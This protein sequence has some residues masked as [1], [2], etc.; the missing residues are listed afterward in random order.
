MSFL[1]EYIR[2]T[3][4][5]GPVRMKL[6]I[7]IPPDLRAISRMFRSAGEE[8]YIVGG[9]VRDTLLNKTPKDYD[10][11][12]GAAP[13]VVIDIISQDPGNKVDLTG[14]SFGVVRVWTPDGSEYEIAT[15]RKDI[16]SGRRPDR[17]EFTSIE[18][19]VKRRDLTINALFYDMGSEEVVDYVGG[20]RDIKAG[21]VK[22]VGDPMQR[23]QEDKLRILRA[24]RFAARLGSDLD[25][26]TE[27]AI[28]AG[29]NLAD[30][31]PDRIRDEVVKG[32][33][34]AQNAT[35]FLELLRN[36]DLYSQIFPGL[37][38]DPSAG[39][40]TKDVPVQLAL[41]LGD[42]NPS[43]VQSVLKSMKYSNDEVSAVI[44]LMK[45]PEVT[46]DSAPAMKKEF[47]RIKM[48]PDRLRGFAQS[49]GV[50]QKVIDSFLRFAAAKPAADP[51]D[52]MSQGL[53]GPDIGAAMHSAETDA[54]GRM[55]GELRYYVRG[56]L[57]E[58]MNDWR[59]VANKTISRYRGK[60]VDGLP[61]FLE[62]E[63]PTEPL[64]QSAEK[65]IRK[66]L[67]HKMVNI[68]RFNRFLELHNTVSY[69]LDVGGLTRIEGTL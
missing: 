10:L 5:R 51:R 49:L 59:D 24:V 21:I 18:D 13:G 8:L 6:E 7:P 38:V 35:H 65:K 55:L 12:T 4:D 41:I 16:G 54:Y 25:P 32:I 11:A 66:D 17:V 48:D 1:R 47:N 36:L 26:K 68:S 46:K 67:Q 19:D 62:V 27:A 30:V 56:A 37:R 29:N 2:E 45:F 61:N 28:L 39:A 22:A 34:T 33:T 53:K 31:S 50:N 64:A 9:A 52:L 43:Q 3:L 44:F 57:R 63:F 58:S 69:R 23:F 42:N 40:N 14:K 15:F 20:I 60:I